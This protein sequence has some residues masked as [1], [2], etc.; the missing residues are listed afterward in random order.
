MLNQCDSGDFLLLFLCNTS[1]LIYLKVY[2][3]H[4]F[5]GQIMIDFL[6]FLSNFFSNILVL[7]PSAILTSLISDNKVTINLYIFL[8]VI[9]VI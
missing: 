8:H 1:R 9:I 4:V 3:A 7:H 2:Y 5:T 6:Y